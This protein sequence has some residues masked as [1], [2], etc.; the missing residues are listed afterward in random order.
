MI[1]QF[2]FRICQIFS[3]VIHYSHSMNTPNRFNP[4]KHQHTSDLQRIA[5]SSHFYLCK[6]RFLGIVQTRL[7]PHVASRQTQE[8]ACAE[9]AEAASWL[10]PLF[11]TCTVWHRVNL[12]C[13]WR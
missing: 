9:R 8:I 5:P 1:I 11:P 2:C 13:A 7:R 4:F 6:E 12:R 10:T 3:H